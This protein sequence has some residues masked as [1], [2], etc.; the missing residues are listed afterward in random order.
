[1]TKKNDNVDPNQNVKTSPDRSFEPS[2]KGVRRIN[3][4]ALFICFGIVLFFTL[5]IGLGA[6]D[7]SRTERNDSNTAGNDHKGGAQ[8]ALSYAKEMVKGEGQSFI[9]ASPE[10]MSHKETVSK[11]S[12]P[13]YQAAIAAYTKSSLSKATTHPVQTEQQK[14]INEMRENQFQQALIADTSVAVSSLSQSYGASNNALL[15]NSTSKTVSGNNTTGRS[16]DSSA[17]YADFAGSDGKDR[18]KLDNKMQEP[19]SAYEVRAG[20]VIPAVMI[21]GINSDLPGQIMAQVSQNVYDTPT[22]RYLLIPQGARLVGTYASQVAFGQS[23]VL[24]G[25]Q[26]IIFPDGKALDIGSMPGADS[27]GYSGFKDQVNNHYLRIFGGALMMSVITAG[28]TL[29]QQ[30]DNKIGNNNRISTSDAIN[31]ALGQQLGQAAA[32][33]ITKNMNIAPTLEIRPGYR[34]NVTLTK[35][36]T[37]KTPYRSFDYPA[38]GKS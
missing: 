24:I 13:T 19:R 20:F 28:I 22:G 21:S 8:S 1:M 16:N 3:N 27:A 29:S 31:E 18:W 17:A 37:F 10:V 5:L 14:K 35:D 12:P 2:G 34:F 32:Q 6:Y 38:G 26:R 30:E 11:S 33:L 23:R 25:W 7:R 9:P 15:T 4:R 36:L